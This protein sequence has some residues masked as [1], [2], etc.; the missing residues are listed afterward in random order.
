MALA[1][2]P[3]MRARRR[4][5]IVN[6]SSVS[7]FL[8]GPFAGAYAISKHALEAFSEALDHEVRILGLRSILIEPAFTATGIGLR[9]GRAQAPL[10]VYDDGREAV[11]RAFEAALAAA[12]APEAVAEAVLAVTSARDPKVRSTVGRQAGALRLLRRLLPTRI[13]ERSFRKQFGLPPA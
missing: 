4:G 11:A 8:P 13:F 9:T 7:G 5:R 1:A 12:P 6:I 2:L 3:L 10:A